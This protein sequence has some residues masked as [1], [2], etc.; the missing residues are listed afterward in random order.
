MGEGLPDPASLSG[1]GTPALWG[2]TECPH[3]LQKLGVN[4]TVHNKETVRHSDLLFLAVKPHLVPSVL[5]EL[6]ADI[7]PLQLV[8]SCA[9]GITISSV[10]KVG[11]RGGQLGQGPALLANPA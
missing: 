1:A 2:P 7:Q 10:E 3:A 5:D 4:L 6:G 11:A 8:V 9:A